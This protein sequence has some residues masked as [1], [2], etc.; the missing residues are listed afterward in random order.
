MMVR[1]LLPVPPTSS[2]ASKSG[3][4]SPTS[5]KSSNDEVEVTLTEAGW[6]QKC[7]GKWDDKASGCKDMKQ[8]SSLIDQ[9]E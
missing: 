4:S 8:V 5:N 3:K 2:S 6:C 1:V 9:R 7:K